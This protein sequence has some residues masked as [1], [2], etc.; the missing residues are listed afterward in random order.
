MPDG[1]PDRLKI[2]CHFCVFERGEKKAVHGRSCEQLLA[3]GVVGVDVRDG[4]TDVVNAD[5]CFGVAEGS[6]EV[7]VCTLKL[8]F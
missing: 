7:F 6:D 1:V 8:R 4:V 5:S 2:A 3:F